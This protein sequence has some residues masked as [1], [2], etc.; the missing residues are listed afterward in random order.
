[1]MRRENNTNRR[2]RNRT[3]GFDQPFVK[4]FEE[5]VLQIKRVSKKTKGGNQMSFTALVIVGDKKGKIG[6]GLGKATN[7]PAAIAKAVTVAKK[8]I[9]EINLKG[10][11]IAYPIEEKFGAAKVL[12]KPAPKGSGIIAGGTVRNVLELVGIKDISAKMMGSNNKNSNVRCTIN[13]LKRL[14]AQPTKDKE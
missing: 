13:A 7:V 3:R 11:T 9:A 6:F 1:M 10:P 2:P 4:E 14:R 5:R 8:G 12:I